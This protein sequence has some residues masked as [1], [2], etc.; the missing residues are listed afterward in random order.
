MHS[1]SWEEEEC[2]GCGCLSP[3]FFFFR[4]NFVACLSKGLAEEAGCELDVKVL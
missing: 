3:V 2:L 4:C 1:G